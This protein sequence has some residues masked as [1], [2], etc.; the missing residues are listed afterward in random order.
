MAASHLACHCG[1]AGCV[2]RRRWLGVIIMVC[3]SLGIVF[4]AMAVPMY[5]FINKGQA[6]DFSRLSNELRC[7][8]CQNQSIADSQAPMA[9]DLRLYIAKGLRQGQSAAEIKQQLLARY[10]EYLSFAPVWQPHTYLLWLMPGGLMLV[11]CLMAVYKW[12]RGNTAGVMDDG[13]HE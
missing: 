5:A 8:V 2:M 3:L 13:G 9:A 10:G 4:D 7:L 11:L 12:V 1:F 6:E